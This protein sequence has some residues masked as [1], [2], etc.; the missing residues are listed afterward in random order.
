LVWFLPTIPTDPF[1]GEPLRYRR[2]AKGY[3]IQSVGQDQKNADDPYDYG[4]ISDLT[5]AVER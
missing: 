2:P 4:L 5:F 1:D 3:M